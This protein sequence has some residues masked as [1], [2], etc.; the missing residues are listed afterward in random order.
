MSRFALTP[1]QTARLRD[2]CDRY[3]VERLDL[4]GSFARGDATPSSDVDL[5]Y[6]IRPGA[7]LG[8]DI[9]DLAA[10]LSATLGRP[11]DL[12]A[13]RALHARL[14]DAALADAQVL[15]PDAN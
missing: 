8:W 7:R 11:V 10:E 6:T 14:R 9:E 15:Y 12:V 13:K 1:D 4:F 2:I 3:G 5:L